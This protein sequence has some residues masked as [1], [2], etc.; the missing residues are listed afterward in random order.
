[1]LEKTKKASVTVAKKL[2]I[3]PKYFTRAYGRVVYPQI[4][5]GGRWLQ[6]AGFK[7]GDTVTVKLEEGKLIMSVSTKTE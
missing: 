4:R 5:F 3:T 1:M 7:S 6:E 2:K